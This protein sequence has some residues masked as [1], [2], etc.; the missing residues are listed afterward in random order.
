MIHHRRPYLGADEC[1][2]D[3]QVSGQKA[4]RV[5]W[6]KEKERRVRVVAEGDDRRGSHMEEFDRLSFQL[7]RRCRS[8]IHFRRWVRRRAH[9]VEAPPLTV[10][11][12]EIDTNARAEEMPVL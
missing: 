1:A 3:G 10:V 8:A 4:E 5:S 2:V 7:C 12:I 9:V 11:S 6:R